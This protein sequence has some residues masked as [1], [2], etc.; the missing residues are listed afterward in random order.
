MAEEEENM[1]KFTISLLGITIQDSGV[2]E[3][4]NALRKILSLYSPIGI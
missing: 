3:K 1:F 4:S 2:K